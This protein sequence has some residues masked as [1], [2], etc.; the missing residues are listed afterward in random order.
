MTR[1]NNNITSVAKF[2]VFNGALAG[3]VFHLKGEMVIGR[4]DANT[5]ADEIPDISLPD[6]HVSRRHARVFI[7]DGHCFLEDLNS[8]NGT[9]LN[10][11]NISLREPIKLRKGNNVQVGETHM[12]F[13]P[14]SG[15]EVYNVNNWASSPWKSE[16]GINEQVFDFSIPTSTQDDA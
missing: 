9:F 10:T 8:T 11:H 4:Q 3:R 14:S 16:I 6:S 15:P 1:K 12:R 2:E 13:F 7:K 5:S